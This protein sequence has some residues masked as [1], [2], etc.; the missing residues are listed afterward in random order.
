MTATSPTV[1]TRPLY[2]CMGLGGPWDVPDLT[3]ADLA[4]A[5]AVV[6][7]ALGIGIT[8]FDHADI[9]AAGKAEAVFG[10]VLTRSPELRRSLTLQTKVGIRLPAGDAAGLYDLRAATITTRVRQ[11]LDRLRTD[12]IDVLLLH[13]P[14][15]LTP[16]AEVAQ[17]LT[18]LRDEGLVGAF[19][20]SNMSAAQIGALQVHLDEPLVVDQ[21]E[22]SLYRRDWV[23]SGVLVNT[24]A[25]TGNG[26]P[27][28]TLEYCAAHG[29]ALQAW[30]SMAQGRYTGRAGGDAAAQATTALVASLA[31]AKN[32]TPETI[33][34]W[35]LQRHPA[36]IA[37][38]IGTTDTDRI[39]ACADAVD[40]RPEL[41]HDEWYRLWTTARGAALP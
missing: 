12:R 9:Y 40:R 17:A 29:I 3:A 11:S 36:G 33:V 39:A 23:E 7:A 15:P 24:T 26:F 35:W 8:C 10:E 6:E 37:P 4:Q 41:T 19:G 34:L 27:H 14:D 16:P 28:G 25:A 38:T 18:A 30:G 13:R 32:T 21:L 2:G 22:M 1:S 20:V 31:E 5:E